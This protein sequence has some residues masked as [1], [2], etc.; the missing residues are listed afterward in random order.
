MHDGGH[1]SM[2]F[3]NASLYFLLV[4]F[5][6]ISCNGD[7]QKD[8]GPK[9]PYVEK[10]LKLVKNAEKGNFETPEDAYTAYVKYLNLPKYIYTLKTKFEFM[11]TIPF[12][13]ENG[14]HMPE[15][16]NWSPVQIFSPLRYVFKNGDLLFEG[17]PL[18]RQYNLKLYSANEKQIIKNPV[19]PPDFNDSGEAIII[20][21]KEYPIKYN[22]Q[23]GY[24]YYKHDN[25][26]L[27]IEDYKKIPLFFKDDKITGPIRSDFAIMLAQKQIYYK[28]APVGYVANGGRDLIFLFYN[29]KNKEIKRLIGLPATDKY[30][31][32]NLCGTQDTINIDRKNR[33]YLAFFCRGDDDLALLNSKKVAFGHI[34]IY[35]LENNI[36]YNIRHPFLDDKN[37]KEQIKAYQYVLGEDENIYYQLVTDKSY[38]IYKISPLWNEPMEESK[39]NPVFFE[40]HPELKTAWDTLDMFETKE[41]KK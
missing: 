4:S 11:V 8:K 6:I 7:L 23:N 41:R 18:Q 27:V 38:Y 20:E 31:E 16:P 19:L 9:P 37:K 13:E 17:N 10:Y 24:Q 12:D 39:Y 35:D 32:I 14:L 34:M 1:D 33:I 28:T 21:G 3:Q 22:D 15:F 26:E 30:S 25:Q 36:L 29:W 40:F 2:K 5:L